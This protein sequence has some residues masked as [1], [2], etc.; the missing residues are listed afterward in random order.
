[1]E[2]IPPVEDD[3]VLRE[4]A[5]S[6]GGRW[7]VSALLHG[8]QP[9]RDRPTAFRRHGREWKPTA[10]AGVGVPRQFICLSK[11]DRLNVVHREGKD[12]SWPQTRSPSIATP[13]R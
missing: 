9:A 3:I 10:L 11:S 1:M 7:L 2:N 5:R 8:G 13:R 4:A 12:G 6:V